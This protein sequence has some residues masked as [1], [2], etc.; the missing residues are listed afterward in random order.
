RVQLDFLTRPAIGVL[1]AESFTH[2]IPFGGTEYEAGPF[3]V[4]VHRGL[5]GLLAV[6]LESFYTHALDREHARPVAERGRREEPRRI[7]ITLFHGYLLCGG[8]TGKR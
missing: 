1:F 8:F 5:L 7:G 6:V 4:E 2:L 3:A